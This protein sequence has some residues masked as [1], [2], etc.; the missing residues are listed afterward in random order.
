MHNI[1]KSDVK[2]RLPLGIAFANM[3]FIVDDH[4]PNQIIIKKAVIIPENEMWLHKNTE[5]M[6]SLTRGIAQ[7]KNRNFAKNDPLTKK[8]D[9]SWLDEIED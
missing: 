1:K 7:A 8:K 2:G 5:A 4:D 3:N 9:M 6:E